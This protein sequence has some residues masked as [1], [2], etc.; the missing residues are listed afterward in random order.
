MHYESTTGLDPDQIQELVARIRQILPP[1]RRRGRPPALGL[2][3]SVV[4]TL[5]LL[6]SNLDQATLADLVGVSQPT[7]SRIHRRL[8]PLVGQA[9][10][11]HIPPVPEILRGR[12]VLVDGT[13]IPIGDRAGRQDHF[14]GKHR[15]VG[16]NVQVL[17]DLG[18]TLLAVSPPQRGSLHDRTALA[19]TGWETHLTDAIGD[20]AYRGTTVVTPRRRNYGGGEHSPGDLECNREISALRAPVERAIAHLKNWKILKT[21]YRG[22]LAELPTIIRVITAL[23]FYR[24]GWQPL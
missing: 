23:E 12:A 4:V 18:G 24:L 16:V 17:A 13:L 6:R 1:E 2:Y 14:S 21:G 8:T 5:I 9:L 15:R 22:R 10:C 19:H 11:L 20:L 7:V 3:R